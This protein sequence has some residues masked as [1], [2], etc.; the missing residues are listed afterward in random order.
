M[1]VAVACLV[2]WYDNVRRIGMC[3]LRTWLVQDTDRAA[4]AVLVVVASIHSRCHSR[5]DPGNQ[6][7]DIDPGLDLA[8]AHSDRYSSEA[9]AHDHGHCRTRCDLEDSHCTAGTPGTPG[10]MPPDCAHSLAIAFGHLCDRIGMAAAPG[11]DLVAIV[12]DI[13]CSPLSQADVGQPLYRLSRRCASSFLEDGEGLR[14]NARNKETADGAKLVQV[15]VNMWKATKVLCFSLGWSDGTEERKQCPA[16]Q[17]GV[18]QLKKE[19]LK[20]PNERRKK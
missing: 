9:A 2:H 8:N 15:E 13:G 10:Y 12:G 16:T 11:L 6:W 20:G 5:A 19:L 14:R 4:A 1:A 17:P 3:D 7:V 18:E